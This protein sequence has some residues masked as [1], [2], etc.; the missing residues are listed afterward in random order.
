MPCR[1]LSSALATLTLLLASPILDATLE[2]THSAGENQADALALETQINGELRRLEGM[3]DPVS[4]GLVRDKQ[5]EAMVA[6]GTGSAGDLAEAAASIRQQRVAFLQTIKAQSPQGVRGGWA[7]GLTEVLL[8]LRDDGQA[9]LVS[10]T[11]VMGSRSA[12]CV[13]QGSVR[14][15]PDGVTITSKA[16]PDR[17]IRVRREGIALAIEDANSPAGTT[18][19]YCKEGGQM[20]G[21]YFHID[22]AEKIMPW[23]L[24]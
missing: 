4:M 2:K 11:H 19:S 10:I 17:P 24:N 16:H 14:Q 18:P 23:L 22:G 13:V 3:L 21:V 9:K 5:G 1:T 15:E 8:D 20:S 7:N 6:S 12:V